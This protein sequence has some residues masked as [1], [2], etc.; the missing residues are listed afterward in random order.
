MSK[1]ISYKID[2]DVL[3]IIIIFPIST[4]IQLYNLY[5]LKQEK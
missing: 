4:K 3:H 1:T 5:I 2:I